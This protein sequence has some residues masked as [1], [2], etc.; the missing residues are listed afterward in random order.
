MGEKAT[1]MARI[2]ASAEQGTTPFSNSIRLSGRQWLMVGLFA[3][4]L[5]VF[6][7]GLWKH[8]EPFPLEPDPRMPH[9][10]SN[11]YSGCTNALSSER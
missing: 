11:D 9:D 1:T 8:L 4:L 6:A 7:P 10:L 2:K 5:V 3:A